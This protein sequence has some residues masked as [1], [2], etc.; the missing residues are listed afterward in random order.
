MWSVP[1]MRSRRGVELTM[2]VSAPGVKPRANHVNYAKLQQTTTGF[3][4][5][6]SNGIFTGESQKGPPPSHNLA[7]QGSTRLE[8]TNEPNRKVLEGTAG[9]GR[10]GWEYRSR[11]HYR[12]SDVLCAWREWRSVHRARILSSKRHCIA[13]RSHGHVRYLLPRLAR[14]ADPWRWKRMRQVERSELRRRLLRRF[15][16]ASD[17]RRSIASHG[18]VCRSERLYVPIHVRGPGANKS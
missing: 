1:R 14:I 4:S 3:A 9:S 6:G 15:L 11:N 16:H 18:H 5:S 13:F 2:C 10:H 8:T 7:L 12:T 17:L